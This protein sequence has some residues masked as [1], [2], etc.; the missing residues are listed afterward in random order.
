MNA[1]PQEVHGY[2]CMQVMGKGKDGGVRELRQIIDCNRRVFDS[3]PFRKRPGACY[4]DVNQADYMD[5]VDACRRGQVAGLS[6]SAAA[7]DSQIYS[8]HVRI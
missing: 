1:P 3:M 6:N 4:V 7:D 5:A 8:A 2:A